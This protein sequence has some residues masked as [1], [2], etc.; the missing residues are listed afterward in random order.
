MVMQSKAVDAPTRVIKRGT[1]KTISGKSEIT[2][3]LGEDA[4]DRLVLRIHSNDGG[5]FFS[6]E[7]IPIADILSALEAWPDDKAITSVA[8]GKLIRGKSVNT[9]AFLLAALKAEGVLR[10]IEKKQRCHELGDVEGFL[11]Q[12]KA[13]QSG[14]PEKS[15]AKV[16]AAP[17]EKP[18]AKAAPNP[19][20]GRKKSA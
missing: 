2:Y 6:M 12:A 9:S 13:L 11:A 10:P 16:Q 1:C 19:A 18:A 20:K 7:W 5:G 17:N 4:D 3:Q 8:L 14:K 15:P